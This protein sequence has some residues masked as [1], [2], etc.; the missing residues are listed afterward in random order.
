MS[1]D[2]PRDERL[3]ESGGGFI[4]L[5][6]RLCRHA[7]L[8]PGKTAYQFL[9]NG[10]QF[11]PSLS[12]ARLQ[13]RSRA[14]AV[15]LAELVPPSARV[16][17]LYPAGLDFLEG[18]LGCLQ[19]GVIAIPAPSP[20][21][22]QSKRSLP[23]LQSIIQD[24]E[25]ALILTESGLEPQVRNNLEQI[26]HT[27]VNVLVT[28]Q[29]ED[30][31]ADQYKPRDI[32]PDDL[33]YLQYTSGSVSAPKGVMISHGNLMAHVEDLSDV[34]QFNLASRALNWLPHHHDYG[35]VQG[36]L[37]P[38]YA[39][40]TCYVMS[41]SS[42]IRKP[43]RWLK[44]IST[45]G[46]THSQGS[47]FGYGYCLNK[48][49]AKKLSGV[50]LSAWRTASVGAEPLNHEV[51][52]RFQKTFL[53]FGFKPTALVPAYGLAE[54]TLVV[55]TRRPGSGARFGRFAT[56]AM[57]KNWV[58]ESDN[59]QQTT[60]VS[61]GLPL[62]ERTRV[63]IVNPETR[64]RCPANQ[65]GEVWVSGLGVAQGYWKRPEAT[66]ETFH[67][68]LADGEGGTFLR[69]GDLGF[70][71]DDELFIVGRLKDVII[72]RGQNHQPKDI[73]FAAEAS[74]PKLRVGRCA[75]FSIP[76]M[77]SEQLVVVVE[78]VGGGDEITYQAAINAINA[79]V[80]K[81]AELVP[82]AIV[83][84]RS[85]SLPVTS[86]GKVQ[87]QAC[88][89]LYEEGELEVLF[90][91]LQDANEE[92][93]APPM[94]EPHAEKR[95][96]LLEHLLATP[97]QVDDTLMRSYLCSVLADVM[98]TGELERL[99]GDQDLLALGIDSVGSVEIR[100]CLE[101]ELRL[102][103]PINL[104]FQYPTLDQLETFLKSQ[105][106]HK[107]RAEPDAIVSPL[108]AART[109]ALDIVSASTNNHKQF[110]LD[111]QVYEHDS[112]YDVPLEAIQN[113]DQV[114]LPPDKA[115]MRQQGT[116]TITD[117]WKPREPFIDRDTKV[118]G[119]GSCFTRD[120][121][122]WLAECGYNQRFPI[123]P[124]NALLRYPATGNNAYLAE[125]FRILGNSPARPA[126]P[127]A[128][129]DEQ[130]R[131]LDA[132]AD[133][134]RQLFG[135]LQNVDV[136]LLTLGGVE[137]WHDIQSGEVLKAP[138][139]LAEYS[140][141]RHRLQVDHFADTLGYLELID[142]VL[143]RHFPHLK[144]IFTLP[145][146]RMATYRPLS[147]LTAAAAMQATLRAALGEFLETR[148]AQM[149]GR[150]HYFPAYELFTQYF[151]DP[152]QSDNIHATPYVTGRLCASFAQMFC[153]AVPQK[154][155]SESL[156]G[157]NVFHSQALSISLSTP[158]ADEGDREMQTKLEHLEAENASLQQVCRERLAVIE[159]L[160]QALAATQAALPPQDR[161]PSPRG[162]VARKLK[163]F[164]N[165]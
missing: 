39:G 17:L 99:K 67:A 150:L 88:R 48:F 137:A 132:A 49:D 43:L 20:E 131:F 19:A 101:D 66:K 86:S 117:D 87:R 162:V 22:V 142:Q 18:F 13:I 144:I 109:D 16:I 129:L 41:P 76:G 113:W 80:A 73:E 108:S 78:F 157:F 51:L 127:L 164:L 15:R 140:P 120:I 33:A 68:R 77:V 58:I 152:Y 118:L 81:A 85:G 31:L 63:T 89:R 54:A 46:I 102:S 141:D 40:A 92:V 122:L 83:L 55:S 24:A 23:R 79:A 34:Y 145:L 161:S 125:Q 135:L 136:L 97:Q 44:A 38:L 60:V 5:F 103:L 163:Q 153:Q 96:A 160:K 146:G 106:F 32:N 69:T 115:K 124:Y 159:E 70:I 29:V 3:D 14:L 71:H 98:G 2:L 47:H 119:M 9:N 93:M 158:V 28:D 139:V 143:Q 147:A 27:H 62:N 156:A 25:V 116:Q 107:S 52:R 130:S 65:I 36:L 105:L 151:I 134:G 64:Q 110:L 148:S 104:L 53:P 100:A 133:E 126:Q 6:H 10:T 121:V 95:Q 128:T 61:C 111:W 45:F 56:R 1:S 112:A 138:L 165:L 154:P 42:F 26:S 30:T 75:A 84:I 35:L 82:H 155:A 91:H 7:V 114:R 149:G 90:Q 59:Q 4:S 57:T 94:A 21:A 37:L 11:G 8:Q 50:D 74:H 123:S 12:Y 72:I